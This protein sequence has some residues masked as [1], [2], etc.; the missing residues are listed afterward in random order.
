VLR[1]LAADDRDLDLFLV[2]KAAMEELELEGQVV[3]SPD[4]G[5]AIEPDVAVLLIGKIL[6]RIGQFRGGRYEVASRQ[7]SCKLEHGCTS[8]RSSQGNLAHSPRGGI[9]IRPS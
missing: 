1:L 2:V 7:R 4:A 9:I 5:I 6:D 3:G 8:E